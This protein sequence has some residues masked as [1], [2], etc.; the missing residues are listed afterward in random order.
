MSDRIRSEP[1]VCTVE[2]IRG[3]AAPADAVPDLLLEVAHGATLASHFDVL[4]QELVGDYDPDLRGFYFVNTDVGAPEVAMAVA[5]R[6][7]R[8]QPR[9]VAMVVRCLIPRTFIDC[10][11]RIDPAAAPAATPAGAMTPGLP[12][13]VREPRDQQLLLSRYARY[14]AVV[15]AAFAAVCGSGGLGLLVHTYAPRSI[16]VAVDADI[17]QALR[18]AYAPERLPTWP[19]RAPVDLITR[20]PEG[21]ELAAAH[22]A[23]RTQAE[24]AAAG[25]E[26]VLNGAYS[27]HPVT[28]AHTFATAYPG[29]TLC[30]ELR[31][32]LLVPG[33]VPFVELHPEPAR[34][35]RTAAPLA[36]AVLSCLD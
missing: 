27:L 13:W 10:N 22:L 18:A 7:V 29:R 30:L 12:P 9:R 24:Y 17:M 1:G 20:D 33:F 5:A 36:A 2:V 16:D 26:V 4:R 25:Y 14:R 28:L 8:T 35:E 34:V 3:S 32:D 21:K 31:R 15:T 23:Q 19:L 6:V 11:R